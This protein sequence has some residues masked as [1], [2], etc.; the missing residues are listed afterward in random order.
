MKTM[1]EPDYSCVIESELEIQDVHS[2]NSVVCS[3][4]L[5]ILY[6]N[7]RGLKTNFKHLEVFIE[8]LTVRPDFIICSESWYLEFFEFYNLPNYKI[9]YNHSHINRA[10]GV[11][12]YINSDLIEST[13]IEIINNVKFLI[14]NVTT[15]DGKNVNITSLYRCHDISKAD[16]VNAVDSYIKTNKHTKNHLVI[17]DFNLDIKSNDIESNIFL[18]N[19]LESGFIPLYTGITRPSGNA[20][21]LGSCIDNVFLKSDDLKSKAYKLMSCFTDHYP[22]L[23]SL[24]VEKHHGNQ[25]TSNT[26][27]DY[28]KIYTE[29]KKINWDQLSNLSDPGQAIELLIE[30][31]KK[32]VSMSTKHN[33]KRKSPRS[34]WITKGI[35]QSCLTKEHLYKKSKNNPGDRVSEDL[36]K[37]YAKNLNK[38]IARAKYLYELNKVQK[39]Q[40]NSRKLWEFVKKKL[41][42]NKVGN[43]NCIDYIE[44]NGEKIS[45]PKDI[46]D[47]F[48]N[49]F[50]NIGP[51]LA[52]EII[53]PKNAHVK[54]PISNNRTIY[55]KPTNAAEIQRIL[56]EMSNK[57]GGVDG[58][59]MKVLKT[60]I[61]FIRTPLADIFN[62][63][64]EKGIWPKP[65]KVAEVVPIYKSGKKHLPTNYRPISLISNIAKLLEKIIHERLISFF[66]ECKILSN[67]QFGFRKNRGTKEAL[68]CISNYIYNNYNQSLPTIAAFL[69]LAKAFDTVNHRLLLAKLEKYGIRGTV[70]CLLKNYL[71]DR[72][73]LVKIG[74]HKSNSLS[75]STGV[76]QGTILGPLLFIVYINDLLSLVPENCIVSYADDTVIL[77]SD[78]TWQKTE[79][80]MNKYLL[81]VNNWI[82]LNELSLNATKTVYMAYG[83]YK[84]SVPSSLNISINDLKIERVYSTKY[85]GV[86]FDF[87]MKW[88]SHI[89]YILNKTKYLL[90]VFSKLSKIM[91]KKSL[92]TIYYAFFHSIA[93]YGII[94]WGGAYNNVLHLLE[95]LQ[96]RLLKIIS[97]NNNDF[98]KPLTIKG[99]FDIECLLYFYT[100]LREKYRESSS[101]T[102][103]KILNLPRINKSVNFKN[104]ELV[105][106]KLFN[107]LPNELKKLNLKK[108]SLRKKITNW[109]RNK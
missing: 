88:E 53:K 92:M 14:T 37:N 95:S 85:L 52:K 69:D 101:I 21:T 45:N 71:T 40:N 72:A 46:A 2:L 20:Q 106:I 27:I 38:V 98:T 104:S 68:A 29:C 17:G 91:H 87:Q 25:D 82:A 65:L 108:K 59:S 103:N 73:Q 35:M 84:N 93:T 60:I 24:S 57:A 107:I 75:I 33:N 16:F 49:F 70:L 15:R 54:E 105:A 10:D 79:E 109:F 36:Y 11:V 9:Y 6:T 4:D 55:L 61:D 30:N 34:L 74:N 32:V 12:I 51:K 42:K 97:K 62:S 102:R 83:I 39:I 100:N 22:L 26:Y 78:T 5:N 50:S 81:E 76:P 89:T 8:M 90:F 1:C 94:A 80:K 66:D 31:I 96:R 44:E 41:N 7:V 58:I 67:N 63:C 13:K 48:N 23:V 43:S 19:F 86:V 77:S 99:S 3:K 28:K 64:I 47:T 18:N 56:S